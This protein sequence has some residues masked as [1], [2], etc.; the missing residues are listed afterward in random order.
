MFQ[1]VAEAM[2]VDGMILR[3][4]L[5]QH[6]QT[7]VLIL[8][9]DKPCVHHEG[10]A[11]LH[12]ELGLRTED[13]DLLLGL[14]LVVLKEVYA[15]LADADA[16][17]MSAEPSNNSLS[18]VIPIV[19]IMGMNADCEPELIADWAAGL[20]VAQVGFDPR[21]LWRKPGLARPP[22]GAVADAAI[23][24]R[25][26]TGHEL[27]QADEGLVLGDLRLPTT[28]PSSSQNALQMA[29]AVEPPCRCK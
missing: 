1:G 9:C 7:H 22:E 21:P 11:E 18:N 17:G 26:P 12:G 20:E 16:L 10:L 15:T 13:A 5:L 19:C 6:T 24:A 28:S 14:A 27:G 29:V 25:G 8:G 4:R 3:H 2:D 23:E